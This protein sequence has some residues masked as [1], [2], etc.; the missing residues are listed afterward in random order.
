M[1]A[2]IYPAGASSALAPFDQ[3]KALNWSAIQARVNRLQ[4]R[5]AK[6]VREKRYGSK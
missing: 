4:I 3:F 6:A 1:T 2:G 5:I